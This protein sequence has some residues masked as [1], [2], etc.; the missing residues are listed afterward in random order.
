MVERVSR[1]PL[2]AAAQTA[3]KS[4]L[5]SSRGLSSVTRQTE[6]KCRGGKE[7]FHANRS[8]TSVCAKSINV[9]HSLIFVEQQA[10]F[11]LQAALVGP[12]AHERTCTHMHAHACAFIES[13]CQTL[14]NADVHFF[15]HQK[16]LAQI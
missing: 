14:V 1:L 16:L 6:W 10:E 7:C 11:E 3:V 13:I 9:C 2:P 15:D 4:S 12:L 8:D 5:R